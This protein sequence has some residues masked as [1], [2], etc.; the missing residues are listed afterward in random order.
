MENNGNTSIVCLCSQSSFDTASFIV[1]IISIIIAVI[2]IIISATQTWKAHKYNIEQTIQNKK[3]IIFDIFNSHLLFLETL[4]S[5]DELEFR[6]KWSKYM[7]DRQLLETIGKARS[8][9][10]VN[11]IQ[12]A[13]ENDIESFIN[14]LKD[15]SNN[16]Q[17]IVGDRQLAITLRNQ[18]RTLRGDIL[19]AINRKGFF[20]PNK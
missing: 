10:Q 13:N 11:N 6:M 4:T 12:G 8:F 16:T 20:N 2:S 1:S 18:I 19:E 9:V 5:F 3:T 15:I 14:I 17:D 7:I